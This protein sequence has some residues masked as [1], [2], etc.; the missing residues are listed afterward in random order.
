MINISQMCD[1]TAASALIE[2]VFVLFLVSVCE[3]RVF[4]FECGFCWALDDTDQMSQLVDFFWEDKYKCEKRKR[5]LSLRMLQFITLS[6]FAGCISPYPLGMDRVG[7][8]TMEL[9][10]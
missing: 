4:F 7:H 10:V 9:G 6:R 1:I 2:D 3:L 5:T 8:W